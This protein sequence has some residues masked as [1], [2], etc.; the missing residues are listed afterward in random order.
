[1][2]FLVWAAVVIAYY[3]VIPRYI[4]AG[5]AP[6][7]LVALSYGF[8]PL[9]VTPLVIGATRSAVPA[10]SKGRT[11]RT[12][13]SAA[14]WTAVAGS[15]CVV[16]IA[17]SDVAKPSSTA[18]GREFVWLEAGKSAV[19]AKLRDPES[20]KFREVY[21]H[22]GSAGIPAACGQVNANNAFGGKTGFQH[23][24][25]VGADRAFLEES[26]ASDEFAVLWNQLCTGS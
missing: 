7:I 8:V 10:G 3:L 17:F 21:F 19:K 11:I 15:I 6:A 22:R 18:E 12:L 9:V 14:L 5:S 16:F 23:F 20:A 13:L 26:M 1:M 24:I 2:G 25:A 4:D